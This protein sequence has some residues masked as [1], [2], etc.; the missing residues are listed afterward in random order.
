MGWSHYSLWLGRSVR[1]VTRQ[2]VSVEPL[3]LSYFRT[4]HIRLRLYPISMA[5]LRSSQNPVIHRGFAYNQDTRPL[6]VI[7]VFAVKRFVVVYCR[8]LLSAVA[9]VSGFACEE[10]A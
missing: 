7:S 9:S 2:N 4:Y 1:G 5:T 10:R 3:I 6:V 8:A